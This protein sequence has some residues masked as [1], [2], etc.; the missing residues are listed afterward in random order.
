MTR[1]KIARLIGGKEMF[2]WGR[3]KWRVRKRKMDDLKGNVFL[4]GTWE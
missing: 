3:S 2:K 4:L 1:S